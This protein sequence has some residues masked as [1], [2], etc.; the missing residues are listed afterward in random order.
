MYLIEGLSVAED[1]IYGSLDVA[2]LEVMPAF[3]VEERVLRSV[4]PAFVECHL[5]SV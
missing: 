5:V 3:V 4:K 1:E 2:I